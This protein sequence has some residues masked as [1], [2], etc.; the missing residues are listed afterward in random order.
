MIHR[1][2]DTRLIALAVLTLALANNALHAAEHGTGEHDHEGVPCLVGAVNEDD[3]LAIPHATALVPPIVRS[4]GSSA[5]TL[6]SSPSRIA[7]LFPPATG[8]PASY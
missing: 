6:V 1:I 2:I 3:V 5:A 4:A 7:V 8:P